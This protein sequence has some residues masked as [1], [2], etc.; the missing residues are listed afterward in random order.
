MERKIGGMRR[1][2]LNAY[3]FH[4]LLELREMCEIWRQ[5]YSTE[6]PHKSLE[7]HSPLYLLKKGIAS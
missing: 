7:Y 6:R 1:E 4:R 3:T 5:D 2:L